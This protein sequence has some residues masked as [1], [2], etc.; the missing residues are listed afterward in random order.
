MQPSR[1]TR[2]TLEGDPLHGITDL[3]WPYFPWANGCV[4]GFSTDVAIL[5]ELLYGSRTW[6][7][8]FSP[9]CPDGTRQRPD[10]LVDNAP[11]WCSSDMEISPSM[12]LPF[13]GDEGRS[14][15]PFEP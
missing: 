15:E 4:E 3:F 12:C 9:A 6:R 1:V 13:T 8:S 2:V 14:R 5:V 7:L 10:P 11:D